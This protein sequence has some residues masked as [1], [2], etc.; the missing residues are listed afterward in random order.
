M[1]CID[2]AILC[3]QCLCSLETAIT[4]EREILLN[5]CWLEQYIQTQTTTIQIQHCPSHTWEGMVNAEL[6]TFDFFIVFHNK[7]D[8][9]PLI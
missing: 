1:A 4:C 5:V 9:H 3:N 6:L 8:Q 7:T 2:Y